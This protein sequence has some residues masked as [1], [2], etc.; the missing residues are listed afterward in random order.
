MQFLRSNLCGCVDLEGISSFFLFWSVPWR[1]RF[2]GWRF[3]PDSTGTQT[4]VER[5]RRLSYQ[6]VYNIGV[7]VVPYREWMLPLQLLP[8][9]PL[10]AILEC[11]ATAWLSTD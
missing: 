7:V 4:L 9:G 10:D 5:P 11:L 1:Q 8:M 2:L 3:P 6:Q